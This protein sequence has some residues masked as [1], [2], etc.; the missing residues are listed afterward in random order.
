MYVLY[1][2]PNETSPETF[3][4]TILTNAPVTS[5]RPLSGFALVFVTTLN[6]HIAWETAREAQCT[7]LLTSAFNVAAQPLGTGPEVDA[8]V[9]WILPFA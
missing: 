1:F 2:L 9:R 5:G 8:V 7:I 4:H 6:E 3:D